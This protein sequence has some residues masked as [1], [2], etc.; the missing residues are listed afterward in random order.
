VDGNING[1][2]ERNLD[3]YWIDD[4]DESLVLEYQM[5]LCFLSTVV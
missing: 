3:D 4:C 2:I 5:S 1:Y